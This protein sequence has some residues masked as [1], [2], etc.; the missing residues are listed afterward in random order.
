MS[1]FN[2]KAR[3]GGASSFPAGFNPGTTRVVP[4]DVYSDS[5]K[6]LSNTTAGWNAQSRLI[7][8]KNVIYIYTDYRQITDE[9]GQTKYVPGLKI[10]DGLAY[11]ADAPFIPFSD[12]YLMDH[13]NDTD[14]HVTLAEKAFWNYKVTTQEVEGETL[15]FTRS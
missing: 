6:I 13:I 1:D 8:Q 9:S 3:F 12:D 14:I 11:L 7:A 10:G 2:S 15:V 4:Y 5:A